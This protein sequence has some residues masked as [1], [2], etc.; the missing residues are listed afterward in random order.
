[1]LEEAYSLA[2][3]Q[4]SLKRAVLSVIGQILRTSHASYIKAAFLQV[5]HTIDADTIGRKVD[6]FVQIA[7]PYYGG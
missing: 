4:F 1:M 6:E 7:N 5:V 3:S 2:N